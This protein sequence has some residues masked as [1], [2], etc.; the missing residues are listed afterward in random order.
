VIT[1]IAIGILEEKRPEEWRSTEGGIAEPPVSTYIY[2]LQ[3]H[4]K[5]EIITHSST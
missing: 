3:S 1:G 2:A 4:I 5:M